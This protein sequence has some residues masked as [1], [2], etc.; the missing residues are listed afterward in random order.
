MQSTRYS[1]AHPYVCPMSV[2][3]SITRT[4]HSKMVEVKIMQYLPYSLPIPLVFAG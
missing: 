2:C 4:D 1:I 3:P